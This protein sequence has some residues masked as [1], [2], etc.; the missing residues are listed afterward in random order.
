MKRVQGEQSNTIIVTVTIQI[1]YT[2]MLSKQSKDD[3][4]H[5]KA[6]NIQ[7]PMGNNDNMNETQYLILV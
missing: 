6:A 4:N 3:K 7:L 2:A 5:F 1:S